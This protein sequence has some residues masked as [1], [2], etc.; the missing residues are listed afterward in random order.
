MSSKCWNELVAHSLPLQILVK[1]IHTEII[2]TLCLNV[3][4]N[5]HLKY[6][7]FWNWQELKTCRRCVNRRMAE[8]AVLFYWKFCTQ[9]LYIK[10][11]KQTLDWLFWFC[12]IHKPPS[13]QLFP[14]T[15]YFL[16]HWMLWGQCSSKVMALR[17]FNFCMSFQRSQHNKLW[18]PSSVVRRE[19]PL[20][21]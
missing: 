3:Y 7:Y 8:C 9:N 15:L 10:K 16:L 1:G 2:W 17:N 6:R 18:E 12:F 19:R 20:N 13:G 11:I 21:L 5:G 4:R 14:H